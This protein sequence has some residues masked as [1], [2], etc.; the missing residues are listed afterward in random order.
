MFYLLTDIH[1]A[2]KKSEIS[3]LLKDFQ[4]FLELKTR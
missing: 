1:L 4:A 2:K 3:I